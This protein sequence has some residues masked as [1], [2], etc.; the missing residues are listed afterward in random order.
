MAVLIG[1][2]CSVNPF[3]GVSEIF[4]YT[5]YL[6]LLT[7]NCENYRSSVE[8]THGVP[9]GPALGPMLFALN[10]DDTGFLLTRL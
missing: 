2:V 6:V 3:Y 5:F 10:I 1:T 7:K 4:C 9:H 8:V